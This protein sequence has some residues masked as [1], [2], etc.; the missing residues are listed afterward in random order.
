M[1]DKT[2]HELVISVGFSG[3]EISIEEMTKYF[4]VVCSSDEGYASIITLLFK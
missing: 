3:N 2:K 4:D 1:V